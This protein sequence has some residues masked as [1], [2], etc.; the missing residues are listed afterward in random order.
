MKK[1]KI[2]RTSCY[3]ASLRRRMRY[4]F[5]QR[6]KIG[7]VYSACDSD[8]GFTCGKCETLYYETESGTL[9]IYD[10]EGEHF[11]LCR[12]DMAVFRGVLY[13]HS[14][15]V[16]LGNR[17]EMFSYIAENLQEKATPDSVLSVLRS[18]FYKVPTACLRILAGCY[19]AQNSSSSRM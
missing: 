3:R 6:V 11:V 8:N 17:D 1:T 5:G 7:R 19:L 4:I 18:R 12:G 2:S 9:A 13:A 10:I 14:A 16:C 15:T